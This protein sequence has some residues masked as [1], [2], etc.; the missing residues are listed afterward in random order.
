[1][2]LIFVC[3]CVTCM[4]EEK[5]NDL[6]KFANA[7]CRKSAIFFICIIIKCVKVLQKDQQYKYKIIYRMSGACRKS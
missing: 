2:L 7:I 1:M 6:N 4:Y 3:L 5:G